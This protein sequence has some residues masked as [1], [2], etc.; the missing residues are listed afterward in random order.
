MVP[1]GATYARQFPT[2]KALRITRTAPAQ[3]LPILTL[4]SALVWSDIF[5]WWLCDIEHG[6]PNYLLGTGVPPPWGP[7]SFALWDTFV[8]YF[9]ASVLVLGAVYST[10][11]SALAF[12][13]AIV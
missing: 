10:V 2:G 13:A 12:V 11:V 6:D 3:Y 8:G 4:L 5:T 1:T 9:V 7:R